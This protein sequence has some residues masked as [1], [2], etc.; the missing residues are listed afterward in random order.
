MSRMNLTVLI[1]SDDQRLGRVVQREISARGHIAITAESGSEA[2]AMAGA[3]FQDIIILDSTSGGE[4][5][6]HLAR[7]LLCIRSVAILMLAGS[8]EE[9]ERARAEGV[10]VRGYLR[11]P[12]ATSQLWAGIKEALEVHCKL[13]EEMVLVAAAYDQCDFDEALWKAAQ[14]AMRWRNCDA[15]AAYEEVARLAASRARALRK[16]MGAAA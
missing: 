10:E 6:I 4:Q 9:I 1:V 11:K 8:D 13:Q 5:A 2:I 12:F 7:N 14:V 15:T 3:S 16:E